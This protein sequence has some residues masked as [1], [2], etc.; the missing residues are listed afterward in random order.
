MEFDGAVVLGEHDGPL[1]DLIL[2]FKKSSHRDLASF[3]A[4]RLA[5]RL[6]ARLAGRIDSF[7][8]VVAVPLHPIDFILRGY[9]PAEELAVALAR[10]LKL[11]VRRWLRKRRRTRSQKRL[12]LEERLKNLRGVFE[13]VG[14]A[15]GRVLLVDDVLTTGAT[16]SACAG[17][18]RCSGA[19]EIRAI[20]VGRG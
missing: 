10:I 3:F 7:S 14:G 17:A 5:E 20:A 1:R 15:H 8:G 18:L 2:A 19:S 6:K 13:A 12:S 4:E 9:N 11:P 16:L